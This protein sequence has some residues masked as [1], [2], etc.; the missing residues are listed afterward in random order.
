VA[1][2]THSIDETTAFQLRRSHCRAVH[3][4]NSDTAP[5]PYR[6][7]KLRIAIALVLALRVSTSVA[8]SDSEHSAMAMR[9]IRANCLSCHNEE[10]S[11]GGLKLT[12]R[13]AM[14]KGGDDGAVVVEGKPEE[15]LLI[16]A[17]AADADPHMPPKKQLSAAKIE[18]LKDWLRAGAPWDASALAG[19][20]SAPRPVALA[21][22][23]ASYRP[24]MA[25]AL[26][27]DGSR[28]A[29]GC[30]NEVVLFDVSPTALTFRARASAHLDPVQSVTWTSDGKRLVTGAFRRVILWNA[31]PFSQQREIVADLTDRITALR[32]L[33]D[34]AVALADGQIS[35]NGMVRILD[36]EAGQIVRSW[37]AHEDTIF[38]MAVSADGRLMATAG[39]DKLVKIWDTAA[40]KEV[41][42]LEAHSTQVLGLAF[43]PDSTQLV[44]AGA[45]RLLKVWDVKTRENTIALASKA[46][47]F[48]A[49]MWSAAGP[50]VL[51][52]TD[53]GALLRYKDL[54]THTGAQSSD[55]GNERQLGRTDSA[56]YCVAATDN[57]ERIF[58][59]SSEGHILCWDKDGKLLHD[60]DAAAASTVANNAPAK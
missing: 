50:A 57:G 25:M 33:P 5:K 22:L 29:V 13:E 34:G 9:L 10:K 16:K 4:P 58:A 3:F 45:D 49:V 42:K 38:S 53:D 46:A 17:L 15:S 7:L 37:R 32:P 11:K 23:P 20:P 6:A 1:F 36:L 31:E 40:G 27:P 56:L 47:S 51:A 21:P 14:L 24:I 60:I 44:T 55:T 59:G 41:A 18:L 43:N 8:G 39:G 2:H 30:R 54:K 52:V 19:Q 12:S 48:N 35:E 26:S 28:L